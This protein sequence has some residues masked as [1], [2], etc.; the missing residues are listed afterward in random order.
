[1]SRITVAA[2]LCAVFRGPDSP[3]ARS[4]QAPR[5]RACIPARVQKDAQPSVWRCALAFRL[6]VFNELLPGRDSSVRII[7]SSGGADLQLTLDN[8][9]GVR[10]T[11]AASLHQDTLQVSVTGFDRAM[12]C[13]AQY[14]P[15]RWHAA[16][17]HLRPGRYVVRV[18]FCSQ[19]GHRWAR[20]NRYL[21]VE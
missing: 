3:S 6:A 9:C 17:P 21:R 7:T 2:I 4:A 11:G 12:D 19:D 5:L 15:E 8:P 16:L 20:H 18:D 10:P 13:P 1:M 14:R